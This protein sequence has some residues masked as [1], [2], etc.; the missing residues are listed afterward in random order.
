MG[1]MLYTR[2]TREIVV[3]GDRRRRDL[4][5]GG[6]CV[7]Y[8]VAPKRKIYDVAKRSAVATAAVESSRRERERKK[9]DVNGK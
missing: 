2:R 1:E 5:A 7:L 3:V 9:K 8:T 6:K 4:C